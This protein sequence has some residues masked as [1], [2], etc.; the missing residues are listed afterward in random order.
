[1]RIS[2]SFFNNPKTRIAGIDILRD[3]CPTESAQKI[4]NGINSYIAIYEPRFLRKLIGPNAE[5]ILSE[6][7]DLRDM[8]V[9]SNGGYSIVAAYIYFFYMRDNATMNTMAGEKVKVADHSIQTT[10]NNRLATLW[11]EMVDECRYI[12]ENVQG[13]CPDRSSEIFHKINTFNL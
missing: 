11:N 1:M 10:A 9:N 7:A 6:N 3:G 4:I 5:K 2:P 8:L 13:I 12:A